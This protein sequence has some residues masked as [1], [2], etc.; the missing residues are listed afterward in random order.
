MAKKT[1]LICFTDEPIIFEIL[2]KVVDVR[3]STVSNFLRETVRMRLAEMGYMIAD[4][5]TLVQTT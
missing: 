1:R 5:K 3:G 4:V 2:Q